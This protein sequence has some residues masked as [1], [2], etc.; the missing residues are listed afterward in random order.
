MDWCACAQRLVKETS[1]NNFIFRGKLSSWPVWHIFMKFYSLISC[2]ILPFFI[3]FPICNVEIFVISR[4]L[5]KKF[6]V[7]CHTSMCSKTSCAN[8]V[9]FVGDCSQFCLPPILKKNQ[10]LK[11]RG[12]LHRWDKSL[13]GGSILR[14]IY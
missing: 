12:G 2:G 7:L 13:P 14:M 5:D 8:V 10:Q 9:S 6:I 11:L 1:S 4:Y 3:L